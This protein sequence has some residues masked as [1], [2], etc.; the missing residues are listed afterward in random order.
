MLARHL[1][2]SS[3]SNTALAR[4]S[5]IRTP[6]ASP[7]ISKSYASPSSPSQSN[8][9]SN[10][11]DTKDKIEITEKR[12]L[13]IRRIARTTSGGKARQ[14]WA[15]VVVGNNNGFAGMGAGRAVDA[16][17]AVQKAT[18]NANKNMQFFPRYDGRTVFSNSE[19]KY[20]ATNLTIWPLPPGSGV[21]S[22]PH[23]HEI[24]RCV[25]IHDIAVK[26]RGS[27]NPMN[28]CKAMFEALA[29]QKTPEHIAR[30]RGKKVEDVALSYFGEAN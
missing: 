10:S 16:G 19:Y 28:V 11:K 20:K 15:M 29:H 3:L 8:E 13:H 4:R 22:S 23:I 30:M 1:L 17:A 6:H 27:R 7:S 18:R 24:C 14:I 9:T 5:I 21:I 25:G 2:S 26:T 12:V